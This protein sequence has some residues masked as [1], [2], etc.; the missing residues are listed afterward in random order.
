MNPVKLALARVLDITGLSTGFR[1]VY[2]MVLGSHLRALNYH[3]VPSTKAE[4]FETQLRFYAQH[5]CNIGLTQLRSFLDGEFVPEK[6]G[7]L[8]SFDDG[9]RSHA[10]VVAPLLEKYGFTGWFMVPA[11][12]VD[13]PEGEQARFAAERS[14]QY[15]KEYGDARVA[16]SWDQLRELDATHVIGCHSTNHRRLEE[17]LSAD[18]REL[19]ILASK[20]RFE[21]ELDHPME[22]FCWVG[23]EEW[24]Y[25]SSAAADIRAAG[26]RLSFMTNSYPI[27]PGCDPLQLQRT[28]IEAAYP[29]SLMRLNLCGIF[30]L[31]YRSKRGRVNAKT[32]AA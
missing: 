32:A 13:A 15:A 25:S 2:G 23:G 16:M 5:F 4:A 21:V 26:Y 10:E 22:T 14:I 28:N 24:S 18:E 30:D 19:E 9:L 11:G 31:L 1:H 7:L 17:N 6:P 8:L 29:A 27:L 12:F 20:R 3:D